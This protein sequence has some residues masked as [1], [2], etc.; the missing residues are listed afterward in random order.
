M[1]LG[2]LLSIEYKNWVCEL[3]RKRKIPNGNEELLGHVSIELRTANVAGHS[4]SLNIPFMQLKGTRI[5]WRPQSLSSYK[6]NKSK[7]S[8]EL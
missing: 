6:T 4:V 3:T 5:T 2:H 1:H 8:A 7:C